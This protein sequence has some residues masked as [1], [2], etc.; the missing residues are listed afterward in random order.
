VVAAIIIA[1]IL[2]GVE[3]YPSMSS[4]AGLLLTEN[5]VQFIFSIDCVLKIFQEGR[6]PWAYWYAKY[7]V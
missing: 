4:D 1:G 3:S 7:V 5:F 2:V 6:R